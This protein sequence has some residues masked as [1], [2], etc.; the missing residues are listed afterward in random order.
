MKKTLSLLLVALMVLAFLVSCSDSHN[1]NV[2]SSN[3]NIA[4]DSPARVPVF[5][6]NE[7]GNLVSENGVEYE[8]LASEAF[9]G[10]IGEL[11]FVGNVEGEEEFTNHL[12]GYFKNGLYSIKG[13]KN[14][15]ILIR[16]I[17]DSEWF[18]IYRKESLS[19]MDY[20]LE[21]CI[22]LE[23]IPEIYDALD[24]HATCNEGIINKST[25]LYFL[26]NVRSQKSPQ[27]AGL[28]ELVKQPNGTFENCYACGAI[29]AFFEEEPNLVVKMIITSY[30][31]LAYSVSIEDKEYVL[32]TKWFKAFENS[33]EINTE[34]W[35][36]N[37][38][39][40]FHREGLATLLVDGGKLFGDFESI[41]I[42]KDIV[43]GD[44]ITIEYTGICITEMT[45][46]SS[47]HLYGEVI[48][49]S[50][51]Y[52]NVIPV[53]I[54][55]LT[56]EMLLDYDA[57]N[58]YV[59]LDRSGR[60]T[61]LD[62]YEG[63][64]VYLVEEPFKKTDDS[65]LYVAC[66]LAYNPRDLEDGVPQKTLSELRNEKVTIDLDYQDMDM[67]DNV[68]DTPSWRHAGY[69]GYNENGNEYIIYAPN[70][71]IYTITISCNNEGRDEVLSLIN[72]ISRFTLYD[73]LDL[74]NGIGIGYSTFDEYSQIQEE[75]LNELSMLDDVES[76]CVSYIVPYGYIEHPK[77]DVYASCFVPLNC[78]N[79]LITSYEQFNELFDLTDGKNASIKNITGKTFENNYV[80]FMSSFYYG[81]DAE[82]IG[83]ENLKIIDN[84][85]Y[86]TK[87]DYYTGIHSQIT[88]EA[89]AL[90]VISKSEFDSIPSAGF[91][92]YFV[93]IDITTIKEPL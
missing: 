91:N 68:L 52:A 27:E 81:S 32:P 6:K 71:Y 17:P 37:Y 93:D 66:M 88:N 56:G 78:K 16:H 74:S 35:E 18:A 42:P 1:N 80:L 48:S 43:A 55:N 38:D 45:Y 11:E 61:T 46:P 19:N 15:N 4:Q 9:L 23:F 70:H 49:Y 33:E 12:G 76:I 69:V 14:D 73:L 29:Y 72:Q 13:A 28:Y 10:Y 26:E 84:N 79:K 20:S 85:L 21:N 54:E 59:I 25:I 2:N 47:I 7:K 82:C 8:F 90:I 57:P 62:K 36:F 34:A 5:T 75:L 40:G 87:Y 58:N 50:F 86:F 41:V 89:Y 92:V 24:S 53:S 3:G 67:I 60:Y 51:S 44:I 83:L 63:D 30:N 22:R 77:N 65:A 39:Y 31:D 64:T